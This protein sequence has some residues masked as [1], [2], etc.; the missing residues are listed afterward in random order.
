[1]CIFTALNHL[2]ILFNYLSLLLFNITC[3]DTLF[4]SYNSKNMFKHF[5]ILE[6][7]KKIICSLFLS[8][9]IKNTFLKLCLTHI[10]THTHTYIQHTSFCKKGL[11]IF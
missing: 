7:F 9:A 5:Y 3:I 1:M 2:Y 10:H 6:V 11:I 8:L 4:F